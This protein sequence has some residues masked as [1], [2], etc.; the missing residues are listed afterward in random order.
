MIFKVPSN[1]NRSMILWQKKVLNFKVKMLSSIGDGSEASQYQY[2]WNA[3]YGISGFHED[4][5]C[6]FKWEVAMKYKENYF[7]VRV[8]EYWKCFEQEFGVEISCGPSQH[9]LSWD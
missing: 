4:N 8:I 9:E 3:R 6:K 2:M 7:P 1:V 5:G